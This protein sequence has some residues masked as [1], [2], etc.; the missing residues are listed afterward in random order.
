[1]LEGGKARM[2]LSKGWKFDFQMPSFS[3][4][5]ADRKTMFVG[6]EQLQNREKPCLNLW[7]DLSHNL[8][9]Y[10]CAYIDSLFWLKDF[11]FK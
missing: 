8:L 9:K 4:N 6:S 1:M 3:P 5:T 11:F 10:V 7:L 2:G